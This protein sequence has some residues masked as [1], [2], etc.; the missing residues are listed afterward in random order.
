VSECG[1]VEA[2]ARRRRQRRKKMKMKKTKKKT[3][4]TAT[5][6]FENSLFFGRSFLV[7]ERVQTPDWVLL[8]NIGPAVETLVMIRRARHGTVRSG[9]QQRQS[10]Q[11]SNRSKKV[12]NRKEVLL[13]SR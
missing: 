5:S 13:V 6:N 11:Q 7:Q 2:A 8:I 12:G 3:R 1:V 10:T 4:L 9:D